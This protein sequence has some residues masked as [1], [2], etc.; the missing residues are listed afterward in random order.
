MGEF[1][2]LKL[3]EQIREEIS[4]L[5]MLQKIKDPRVSLHD[6]LPIWISHTQRCMCQV[7]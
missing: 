6:A 7:S 2:M 1:R 4:K 3:G 5:I